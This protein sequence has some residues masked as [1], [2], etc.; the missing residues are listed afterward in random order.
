MFEDYTEELLSHLD[1]NSFVIS[2]GLY[3]CVA[4]K[5]CRHFVCERS[6][7][8]PDRGNVDCQLYTVCDFI[9]LSL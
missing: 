8:S 2:M 1:E 9:Y 4:V 7:F 3:K 6:L 5:W